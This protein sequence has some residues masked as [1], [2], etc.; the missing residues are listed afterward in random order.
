VG[1]EEEVRR[2]VGAHEVKDGRLSGDGPGRLGQ[3]EIG[4][5]IGGQ[6]LGMEDKDM[7]ESS[8]PRICGGQVNKRNVNRPSNLSTRDACTHYGNALPGRL[9][10][11][12]TSQATRGAQSLGSLELF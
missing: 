4:R 11:S 9:N 5:S 7:Q 3:H 8:F 10:Q 12:A 2:K 1:G 6:T